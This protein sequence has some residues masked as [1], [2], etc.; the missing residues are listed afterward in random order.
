MR[1]KA[2]PDGGPDIACPDRVR[3]LNIDHAGG[4]VFRGINVDLARTDILHKAGLLFTMTDTHRALSEHW[5]R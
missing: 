2:S 3:Y 4:G 5:I 1:E